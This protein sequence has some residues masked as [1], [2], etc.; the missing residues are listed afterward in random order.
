MITGPMVVSSDIRNLY[1]AYAILYDETSDTVR[2]GQGV[3]YVYNDE[4]ADVYVAGFDFGKIEIDGGGLGSIVKDTTQGQ[5]LATRANTITDGNVP[6]WDAEKNMF[7]DSGVSLGDISTV[8]D[9]ILAQ[10]E[11]IIAMQNSLIG[12]STV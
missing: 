5:A 11:A 6:E 7:V 10:Q 8:F 1:P 3:Y 2:V 12:G 9:S 4:P